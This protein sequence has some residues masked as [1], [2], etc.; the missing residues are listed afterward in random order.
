MGASYGAPLAAA[1]SQIAFRSAQALSI[2]DV[3]A[4]G[5]ARIVALEAIKFQ[6]RAG[7]A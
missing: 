2:G 5:V 6:P 7:R 3:A 4:N 1:R